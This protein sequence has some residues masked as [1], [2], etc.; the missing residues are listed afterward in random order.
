MGRLEVA[1]GRLGRFSAL[2]HTQLVSQ[3]QGHGNQVRAQEMPTSVDHNEH[4]HGQELLTFL[5][6]WYV[7]GTRPSALVGPARFPPQQTSDS[8]KLTPH[9]TGEAAGVRGMRPLPK[10][11]NSRG[12]GAAPPPWGPGLPDDDVGQGTD[13]NTTEGMTWAPSLQG[14]S[15]KGLQCQAPLQVATVVLLCPGKKT[16]G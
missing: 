5:D 12:T 14:A 6:T 11:A 3:S 4:Q 1:S 7:L 8:R 9:F 10:V 16:V 15:L 2:E 13:R